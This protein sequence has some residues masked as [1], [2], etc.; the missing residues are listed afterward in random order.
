MN[1]VFNRKH[2]VYDTAIIFSGRNEACITCSTDLLWEGSIR[3]ATSEVLCA[4][5]HTRA[6]FGLWQESALEQ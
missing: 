1:D 6:G 2:S 4:E 3:K 5:M